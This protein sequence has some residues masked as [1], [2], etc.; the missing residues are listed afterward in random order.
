MKE[1]SESFFVPDIPIRNNSEDLF[2]FSPVANRVASY[3][4]SY[5]GS[6]SFVVGVSGSWGSGKTSLLHLLEEQFT[7]QCRTK[8]AD[9]KPILIWYSPWLIGNRS[10]RLAD[11]LLF[12]CSQLEKDTRYTNWV[13][14]YVIQFRKRYWDY[15]NFRKYAKAISDRDQS[16]NLLKNMTNSIGVPVLSDIW[17][18]LKSCLNVITLKSDVTNL[19]ELR[20]SA[21]IALMKQ[22]K[23]ILVFLDDIDRLEPEEVIAI[24]RLV[25]STAQLPNM[26]YFLSFDANQITEILR[27][28]PSAADPSFTD[29]IIQLTVRVPPIGSEHLT[30][31]LQNKL[32][33][34]LSLAGSSSSDDDS[35]A[36]HLS[37]ALRS[38]SQLNA[39]KTPR[40]VNRLINSVSLK[41]HEAEPTE[42]KLGDSFLLA[43]IQ[44]NFPNVNNWIVEYT[45]LTQS[46]SSPATDSKTARLLI[47]QLQESCE[48]DGLDLS[49]LSEIIELLVPNINWSSY[50]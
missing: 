50:K 16:T 3:L 12:V 7:E 1:S 4:L 39:L 21:S 11:F 43:V 38:I 8:S 23:R 31:I 14:K 44:E 29:K 48:Q 2:S 5:G 18:F 47:E 22:K 20:K 25:R 10:A 30:P 26:T 19:D 36:K 42:S 6:E 9:S 49:D 45:Q 24:F 32:T 37:V 41:M 28:H 46:E 34:I 17:N 13:F 35:K 27:N 40:D 33:R 15:R